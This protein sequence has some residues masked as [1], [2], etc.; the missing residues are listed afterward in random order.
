MPAGSWPDPEYVVRADADP[1]AL[2][3]SIRELVRS[4]DRSRPLF[5]VRRVDEIIGA[6]LDEPRLNATFLTLFAGAAL[7]LAALGLYGLLTLLIADR[8]REFG[9]RIALGASRGDLVRLVLAGAGR[10][11]VVGT[12]AGLILTFAASQILHTVLFGITAHDSRALAGTVL[13]LVIA[14]ALALAI[15]VKQ[16]MTI[17]PIEAIRSE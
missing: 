10:L 9:V 15:P 14:S 11:I 5:G 16:A 12:A 3:T 4:L 6:S 13:A 7:S 2:V 1:R 17:D 8:R